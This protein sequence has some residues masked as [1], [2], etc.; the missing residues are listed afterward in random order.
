VANVPIAQVAATGILN[1]KQKWERARELLRDSG[2]DLGWS[3]AQL[4]IHPTTLF[5]WLK[6][7]KV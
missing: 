5:R 6:A 4:G 3:A 2:H 1:R 7:G